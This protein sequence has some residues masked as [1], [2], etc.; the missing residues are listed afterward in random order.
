MFI[1]KATTYEQ[2]EKKPKEKK[3]KQNSYEEIRKLVDENEVNNMVKIL[4]TRR[5][6]TKQKIHIILNY[7]IKYSF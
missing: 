6:I 3:F 2:L 5:R 7:L 4:R 1:N